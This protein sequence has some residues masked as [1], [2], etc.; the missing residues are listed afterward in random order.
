MLLPLEDPAPTVMMI[1]GYKYYYITAS[2]ILPMLTHLLKKV[3]MTLNLSIWKWPWVCYNAKLTEAFVADLISR[4]DNN[5]YDN[6]L[7]WT[8]YNK[9]RRKYSK[10]HKP[11]FDWSDSDEDWAE[12]YVKI[13]ACDASWMNCQHTKE[14]HYIEEKNL[15]PWKC[16]EANH[17]SFPILSKHSLK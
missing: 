8:C 1:G 6:W 11:D 17:N 10:S 14:V 13:S 9:A 5:L 15:K 7:L 16:W 2:I 4:K 3:T 12:F